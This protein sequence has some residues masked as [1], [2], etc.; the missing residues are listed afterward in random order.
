MFA[1]EETPDAAVL[2]AGGKLWRW[3]PSGYSGPLAWSAPLAATM[4]TPPSTAKAVESG[5]A[6][7]IHR[8]ALR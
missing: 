6:P 8:S 5:Y 3:S 1:L 7:E 4:L 2:A